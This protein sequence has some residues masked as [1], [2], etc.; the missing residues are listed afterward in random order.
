M[1]RY[2]WLNLD[3]DLELESDHYRRSSR[4]RAQIAELARRLEAARSTAPARSA[5][6]SRLRG[7]EF[8]VPNLDDDGLEPRDAD[9]S[10]RSHANPNACRE[11]ACRKSSEVARDP[12][13]ERAAVADAWCP[14]P[15]AL[16]AL[17]RR[18]LSVSS[19]PPLDVLRRVN[20]RSFCTSLGTT[21]PAEAFVRSLDELDEHL[22]TLQAT[23]RRLQLGHRCVLKRPFGFSG[24]ARK[25]LD[26]G[27]WRRDDEATRRWAEA[28]MHGYGNG[29]QVEPWVDIESEF[30]IHGFVDR[31][32][33]ARLG[34]PRVLQCDANGAWEQ[35]RDATA[36]ELDVHEIES[37]EHEAQRCAD[38]LASAA[39]HGPFGV[40]AF[41]WRDARGRV[42]FRPRSEL[43][44]RFTMGFF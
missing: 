30:S 10:R 43:N 32:G 29:L 24:R 19:T 13:S 4:M 17:A 42:H 3:A 37:L 6:W 40:D 35:T 27:A 31:E 14:T 36:G 7:C 2:L 38:A 22:E 1:K 12:A 23:C 16:A 44:A 41:R 39:Y 8:L 26:A 11:A 9:H 25:V 34:P 28:S 18:G 15:S 5:A 20:H 21:L 33:V